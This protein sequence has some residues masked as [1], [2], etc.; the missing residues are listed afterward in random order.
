MKNVNSKLVKSVVND[1][2]KNKNQPQTN[3][4]SW[5]HRPM[6]KNEMNITFFTTGIG[7]VIFMSWLFSLM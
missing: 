4:I 6:T 7:W 3:K 1:Y 2:L 5:L